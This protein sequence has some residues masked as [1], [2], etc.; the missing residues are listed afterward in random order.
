MTHRRRSRTVIRQSLARHP[1]RSGAP[2]RARASLRRLLLAI[3]LALLL[4]AIAASIAQGSVILEGGGETRPGATAAQEAREHRAS[5]R[6]ERAAQARAERQQRA[7]GKRSEREQL[8]ARKR[9]EREVLAARRRTEREQQ[10]G[11]R[12]VIKEGKEIGHVEISCTKIVWHLTSFNPGHNTVTEMVFVNGN[13]PYELTFSFDGTEG[14]NTTPISVPPGLVRI[15]AHAKWNTNGFRQNFDIASHRV[16]THE[17]TP[18]LTIEK[19]QT[20]E[21]SGISL[22]NTAMI[23][24]VGQTVHYEIVVT[25]VGNV[26]LSLSG[27]SDPNCDPGTLS[28]GASSLERGAAT[29]FVCRHLLTIAD[30]TAGSYMN[31]ATITGTPPQGTPITKPSNTVVVSFAPTSEEPKDKHKEKTTEEPNPAGGNKGTPG[32]NSGSSSGTGASSGSL[33][34]NPTAAQAGSL[35]AIARAPALN[36]PQGCVRGNFT[37]SVRAPRVRSVSFYLDGHRLK[38]LTA[39]S[40]RR[41]RLSIRIDASRLRIGPH[42]LVA[43]FTMMGANASA[44]TVTAS[45]SL[46]FVH[47]A[48]VAITP[49][50]TG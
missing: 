45:R 17:E 12:V 20:I 4:V 38:T 8:T 3:P 9:A 50:F 33:P 32:T 16:C 19:R 27:F 21:G 29:K 30:L 18:A 47:C 42:R 49:K 13:R 7:A 24:Q 28:G 44:R 26:T 25:N 40:A 39:R 23:G 31:T 37:V 5:E 34:G 6:E 1:G 46:I 41:G 10:T 2:S 43:R 14:S 48:S 15:D 36:G 35:A 11:T 22:T